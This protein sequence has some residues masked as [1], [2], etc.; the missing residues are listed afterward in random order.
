MSTII[1]D[2][3]IPKGVT[4]FVMT[5]HVH[6]DPRYFP[7]PERFDPDRWLPENS[8]DQHPFAFVAFSAG[9]RNCIGNSIHV[10]RCLFSFILVG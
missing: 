1:G 7:D 5:A 2:F 4:T 10:S 9:P 3:H 8:V 6:R